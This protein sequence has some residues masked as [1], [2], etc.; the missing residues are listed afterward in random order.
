MTKR[1][2]PSHHTHIHP[3]QPQPPH[4][5][6]FRPSSLP[7]LSHPT[8]LSQTIAHTL[9]FGNRRKTMQPVFP[10][11]NSFFFWKTQDFFSLFLLCAWPNRS[12]VTSRTITIC[13][14]MTGIEHHDWDEVKCAPEF[15]KSRDTEFVFFKREWLTEKEKKR[16]QTANWSEVP[17]AHKRK[18]SNEW[19]RDVGI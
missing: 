15:E 7:N 4:L 16:R 12:L 19:E 9:L 8:F 17:E 3:I 14:T 1:L 11:S 10:F 13:P 2:T 6:P 18:R 5:P